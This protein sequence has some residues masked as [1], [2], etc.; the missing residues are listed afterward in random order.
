M[1]ESSDQQ[2]V[3]AV[4]NGDTS[5][6]NVL[7]SR[8]QTSLIRFL[9]FRLNCEADAQDVF[10]ETFLNAH[11]YISSYNPKF[12]FSTW[13]FNIALRQASQLHNK[14]SNAQS[15]EDTEVLVESEQLSESNGVFKATIEEKNNIWSIIKSHLSREHVN[16]LWFFY[17]E[18]YTS[19]QIS[20][21]M[22]RS[23][24]W[25]KINLL[26]AKAQL[27]ST[28]HQQPD[29]TFYDMISWVNE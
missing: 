10:Q 18:D 27:K 13:L 16:L 21:V 3:Q 26:R 28:L 29:A 1:T 14:R 5:A 22:N 11:Q 2:L 6:F 25:V 17:V 23:V 8:Y 9:R 12:A 19:K 15:V 20:V 4:I 24:A 7:V